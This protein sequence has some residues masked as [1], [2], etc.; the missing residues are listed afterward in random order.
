MIAENVSAGASTS[1]SGGTQV[2]Y[3]DRPET[4]SSQIADFLQDEINWWHVHKKGDW[5]KKKITPAMEF[6]SR[7]HEMIEYRDPKAVYAVMPEGM[8]SFK[9]DEVFNVEKMVEIP[10]RVLNAKGEKRGKAYL[11]FSRPLRAQGAILVDEGS[12]TKLRQYAQWRGE[13]AGK[14]VIEHDD[15]DP[16]PYETIWA[17]L[18]SVSYTHLTLP[19]KA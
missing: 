13:N 15:P 8:V 1:Q 16:N 3:H 6:G 11:D 5:P 14:V 10:R 19:T 7:V 17:H 2:N 18:M 12:I 4:S 9:D